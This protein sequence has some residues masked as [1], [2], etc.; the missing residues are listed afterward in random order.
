[1]GVGGNSVTQRVPSVIRDGWVSL[2]VDP[3]ASFFPQSP[4]NGIL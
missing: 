3:V 2:S 1:M 4:E